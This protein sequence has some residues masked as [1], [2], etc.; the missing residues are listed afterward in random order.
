MLARMQR[1]W[2]TAMEKTGKFK[3]KKKKV[4]TTVLC[5][6]CM[7][8]YSFQRKK[9]CYSHTKQLTQML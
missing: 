2:I 4:A 8:R 6:S 7:T 3:K 1:K 9:D 5:S